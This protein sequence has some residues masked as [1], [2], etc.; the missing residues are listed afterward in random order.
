MPT[1]RVVCVL[2]VLAQSSSP[3]LRM[4]DFRA[5]NANDARD[6]AAFRVLHAQPDLPSTRHGN[7]F[8]ISCG[9]T[10]A[11]E[12]RREGYIRGMARVS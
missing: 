1:L 9:Y 3:E 7:H 11:G 12:G 6:Y 4:V 2:A 8:V 5:K 10:A